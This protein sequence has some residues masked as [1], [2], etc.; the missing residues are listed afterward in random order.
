MNQNDAAGSIC[1]I[2]SSVAGL[3]T[4]I[5]LSELRKCGRG[6]LDLLYREL[7][8][9]IEGGGETSRYPPWVGGWVRNN[10]SNLN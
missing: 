2:G 8:G 3:G 9:R 6:G 4:M 5:T 10:N 1:S 7:G